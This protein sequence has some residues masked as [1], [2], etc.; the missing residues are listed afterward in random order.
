MI[1]LSYNRLSRLESS[2][3][4]PIVEQMESTARYGFIE[5]YESRH[6]F[7]YKNKIRYIFKFSILISISGV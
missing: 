2:V 5:V 1:D 3:F 7:V 4:Q 6:D